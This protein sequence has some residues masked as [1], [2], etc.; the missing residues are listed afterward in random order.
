M[1]SQLAQETVGCLEY[2]MANY[3]QNSAVEFVALALILNFGREVP[4]SPIL[5]PD[6]KSIGINVMAHKLTVNL[7]QV[8]Y[9]KGVEP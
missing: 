1:Y 3:T 5:S 6:V 2:T 8:L 9:V 7:I 4:S